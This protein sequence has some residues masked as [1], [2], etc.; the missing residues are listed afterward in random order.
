MVFIPW[1]L[2]SLINRKV[3]K[4]F[5]TCSFIQPPLQTGESGVIT[6]PHFTDEEEEACVGVQACV[7]PQHRNLLHTRGGLCWGTWWATRSHGQK[8]LEPR[9]K[10]VSA[11]WEPCSSLLHVARG[12]PPR[13]MASACHSLST[14]SPSSVPSG[15]RSNW[16]SLEK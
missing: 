5:P 1:A 16:V 9:C 8:V 2:L 12:R 11:D 15:G 3:S 7:V 13:L 10:V 14:W 6:C 4:P